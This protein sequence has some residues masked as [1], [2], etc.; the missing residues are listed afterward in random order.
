MKV[1]R[2]CRF[3]GKIIGGVDIDGMLQEGMI[4]TLKEFDG[5][6]I[7][8]P[9]GKSGVDFDRG[10]HRFSDVMQQGHYLRTAEE[11]A[12]WL[13]YKNTCWGE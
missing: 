10:G 2:I 5:E 9:V 12:A 4:Y 6:I 13:A 7:L 8:S 1:A 11:H 3:Y